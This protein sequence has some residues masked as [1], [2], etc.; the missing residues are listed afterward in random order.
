MLF[1]QEQRLKIINRL[2][3]TFRTAHSRGL[4]LN[5]TKLTAQICVNYGST[6]RK[7]KEYIDDLLAAEF[8][9]EGKEGLELKESEEIREGS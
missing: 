1:A 2:K 4:S 3:E 5:R 9:V 7:A 6:R 8:I